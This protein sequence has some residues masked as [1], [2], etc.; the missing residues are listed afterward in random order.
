MTKLTPTNI[1]QMMT[2]SRVIRDD[3]PG[4]EVGDSL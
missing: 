1:M 2:M 4:E 3:K